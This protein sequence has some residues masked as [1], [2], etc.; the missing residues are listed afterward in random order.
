MDLPVLLG[1]VSLSAKMSV[2]KPLRLVSISFL[3][4][5]LASP[6]ACTGRDAVIGLVKLLQSHEFGSDLNALSAL[7]NQP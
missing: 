2:L 1:A 6:K 3:E 4:D 5:V 7:D